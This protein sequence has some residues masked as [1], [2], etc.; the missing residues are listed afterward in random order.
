MLAL[1][2]KCVYKIWKQIN[3][4]M[5]LKT[6]TTA[7]HVKQVAPYSYHDKPTMSLLTTA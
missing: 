5:S 2:A 3:M 7:G 4:I 1:C 6:K